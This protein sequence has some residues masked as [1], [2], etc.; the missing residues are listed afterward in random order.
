MH[1]R[2]HIDLL[3]WRVTWTSGFYLNILVFIRI[4]ATLC[5]ESNQHTLLS[6]ARVI[7]DTASIPTA[8]LN[9]AESRSAMSNN[10]QRFGEG[11][12]EAQADGTVPYDNLTAFHSD[13]FWFDRIWIR[14]A[15]RLTFARPR[16]GLRFLSRPRPGPKNGLIVLC[17][18]LARQ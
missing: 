9:W 13:V 18:G 11:G 14:D 7:R 5:R 10:Y 17:L 1:C 8:E 3:S 4:G 2:L 6:I 12:S 16:P 15:H